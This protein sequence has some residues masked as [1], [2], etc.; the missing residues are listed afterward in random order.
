MFARVITSLSVIIVEY[1][2]EL[3]PQAIDEYMIDMV[4]KFIDFLKNGIAENN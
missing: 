2:S 3:F 4:D 1:Y